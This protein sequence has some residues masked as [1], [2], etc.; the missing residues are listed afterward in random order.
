[1]LVKNHGPLSLLEVLPVRLILDMVAAFYRLIRGEPLNALA[2]LRSFLSLPF[3]LPRVL[4]KRSRLS[5]GGKRKVDTSGT[6]YRRSIVWD[7]YVRKRTTFSRLP[8][9]LGEKPGH[10]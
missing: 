8:V 3:L 5:R 7:Y 1:M 4:R 9:R 10:A 2:V 6:L